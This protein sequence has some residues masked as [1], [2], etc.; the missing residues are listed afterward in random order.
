[1]IAAVAKDV[2]GAFA[3]RRHPFLDVI[4]PLTCGISAPSRHRFDGN[5][6]SRANLSFD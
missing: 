1:M 4:A 2:A 6:K 5:C 3:A